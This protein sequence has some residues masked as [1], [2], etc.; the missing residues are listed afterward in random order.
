VAASP[1]RPRTLTE[2]LRA[3][4]TDDLTRLLGER[5]DLTYPPPRE[6]GDLVNRATTTTS[7]ARALDQLDAW[8]RLVAEALSALPDPSAAADVARL[9]G[10]PED[11]VSGAVHELRA[12]A[13]LWGADDQLHLV[14]PVREAFEPYPLGLAAPSPRPLT[15][16]E[17]DAA[18]A[19]T[20]DEAHAVLDRLTWAP[21]GAVRNAERL[22]SVAS[23]RTPVEQLLARRLLRPL[24]ADT[25]ILPREVA[26]HLRA[27]RPTPQPV[28]V[29]APALTGTARSPQLTDRAAAGAAYGLLHDVELVAFE[30]EATPHRLLR[31]GGL[32]LRDVAA[33]ARKLSAESAYAIFV[34]ECAH[35]AGLIGSANLT[36][37][38]TPDLDSWLAADGADR[39][40]ALA[41]GWRAAP[42]FFSRSAQPGVHALGPEAEAP[43]APG[44]RTLLLELISARPVGTVV[45]LEQLREAA[46]WH[47]PRLTGAALDAGTLVAWTAR[48]A[49]WL[50]LLAM[51]AVS[52]FATA[53]RAHAGR[54][55]AAVA[56]LFPDVIDG[57]VVQ[58]DLTAVAPGPLRHEVSAE[59]RLLADQESR[60]GGGVFRF[61]PA[62]VRRAFDAGWS[63]AEIHRWLERHSTTG[64][65]QPLSYLVDDVA[66]RHGSIRVGSAASYLRI[67]DEAQ[68]AAMLAHPGASAL[69]LR[70]V[71][72]GLLVADGDAA[73]V[74]ELLHTLGHTPA[75]ED[76]AGAL[77]TTPARP[78]APRRTVAA[79]RTVAPAELAAALASAERTAGQVRPGPDAVDSLHSAMRDSVPVRVSYVGSDGATTERQLAP[80]DVSAGAFRAVDVVS[81]QVVTIPL[82]RIAS[83]TS[84]SIPT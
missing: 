25:V 72:P 75:V 80:L 46:T 64:V 41:Q 52:S 21:A 66:R 73:E 2:A 14:R 3:F 5:P 79:H 34:L 18:L 35:A 62:S 38:P 76:A 45:D 30:L 29:E 58:A 53:A 63:S 42:R 48:E 40:Q 67:D 47:R 44:L 8:H 26:W 70:S 43:A 27:G 69:G 1:Q 31:T 17:I 71:G 20:P 57:L 12:R 15:T 37:L 81:E 56:E 13:L 22:V 36:L 16:E 24:D 28:P 84:T 51:G 50:G 78:R 55:P 19:A 39:W 54:L 32:G 77:V 83:V 33:L 7:V 11:L 6:L 74:V 60:G 59:L 61:S 4:S 49:G 23:A 65:P 9:I 10:Q 68:A 82:G